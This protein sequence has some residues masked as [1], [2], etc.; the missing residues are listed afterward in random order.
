MQEIEDT[1]QLQSGE[2]AL[3]V[4]L[5]SCGLLTC[6]HFC[7]RTSIEAAIVDQ[8]ESLAALKFVTNNEYD[9]K[10]PL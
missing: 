5:D 8:V 2:V 3:Q 4:T 6:E 9:I 10:Y 1:S 7:V